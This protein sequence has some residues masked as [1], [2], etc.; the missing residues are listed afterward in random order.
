MSNER[1]PYHQLSGSLERGLIT[2]DAY[3]SF[4]DIDYFSDPTVRKI[5]TTILF[6]WAI[7]HEDVGYRQVSL[8]FA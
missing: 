6:L 8:L 5:L 1:E 7:E 3:D 2:A 4:P